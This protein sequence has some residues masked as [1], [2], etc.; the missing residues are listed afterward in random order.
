MH[1]SETNINAM[2]GRDPIPYQHFFPYSRKKW[3]SQLFPQLADPR[4]EGNSFCLSFGPY[5]F[6][7]IIPVKERACHYHARLDGTIEEVLK[8]SASVLSDY[9]IEVS[10]SHL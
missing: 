3:L 2:A 9:L 10:Q 7:S 8:V 6:D 4:T 1:R 5:E